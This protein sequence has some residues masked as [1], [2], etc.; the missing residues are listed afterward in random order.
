M[1]LK[2]WFKKKVG[3]AEPPPL[4]K[5][6]DETVK[7]SSAV[8]AK[9]RRQTS[10]FLAGP[11]TR[12]DEPAKPDEI[13]ASINQLGPV[14][15]PDA[16]YKDLMDE[17]GNQYLNAVRNLGTVH[18]EQT[19]GLG[20]EDAFQSAFLNANRHMIWTI[21]NL[22]CCSVIC[23]EIDLMGRDQEMTQA[24]A[25]MVDRQAIPD[26]EHIASEMG[27]AYSDDEDSE[28]VGKVMTEMNELRNSTEK[29]L[30]KISELREFFPQ[31]AAKEEEKPEEVGDPFDLEEGE[32]EGEG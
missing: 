12:T 18:E 13:Q 26:L 14:L 7:P 3:G 11:S 19:R 23:Q 16:I 22:K 31:F 6:L 21:N 8:T 9:P 17:L 20:R 15:G 4:P 30:M 29:W 28:Y 5:R 1:G 2:D 24:F 27:K 32:G 10:T 25:E